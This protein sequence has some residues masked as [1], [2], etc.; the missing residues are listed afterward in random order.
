MRTDRA[1]VEMINAAFHAF[2]GIGDP[3]ARVLRT[4][5]SSRKQPMKSQRIYIAGKITGLDLE[6]AFRTFEAAEVGIRERGHE[7]LNPMKLVDQDPDRFWAEDMLDA[8]EIVLV[9]AQAVYMLS[10]W[11]DSKGA[12]IEHAIAEQLGLPIYYEESGPRAGSG[13]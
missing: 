13:R 9:R 4:K 6:D 2:G 3:G 11:R 5:G 1:V 12:R 7:P 10:N 8:I